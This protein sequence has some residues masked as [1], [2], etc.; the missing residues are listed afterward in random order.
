MP[1]RPGAAQGGGRDIS[2]DEPPRRPRHCARTTAD[3]AA[4]RA[5]EADALRRNL[6][7]R[8]QQQRDRRQEPGKGNVKPE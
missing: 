1:Q 7:K 3:K 4:R 5:R 8:K 6:H 2:E